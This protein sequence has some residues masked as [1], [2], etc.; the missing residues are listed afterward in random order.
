MI[1]DVK[2]K[3]CV[4]RRVYF[5]HSGSIWKPFLRWKMSTRGPCYSSSALKGMRAGGR[6]SGL[7][8]SGGEFRSTWGFSPLQY[9]CIF[10]H[11]L[12]CSPSLTPLPQGHSIVCPLLLPS[13]FVC[14][15]WACGREANPEMTGK[16][17]RKQGTQ[18]VSSK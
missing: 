3:L 15:L 10:P 5:L 4:Q 6:I 1:V 18:E 12:L 16:S 14:L 2:L 13:A 17:S 7:S 9:E 8:D 11:C